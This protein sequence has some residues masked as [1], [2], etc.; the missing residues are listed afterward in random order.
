MSS[1]DDF[2]YLEKKVNNLEMDVS[3]LL[4]EFETLQAL[5]LELHNSLEQ[6][7]EMRTRHD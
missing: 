6:L 2:Y 4:R 5:V 3:K 7:H 1:S